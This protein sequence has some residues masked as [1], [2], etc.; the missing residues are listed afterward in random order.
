MVSDFDT[1]NILSGLV[2]PIPTLPV[3]PCIVNF[4]DQVALLFLLKILKSVRE[5]AS[6]ELIFQP[7]PAPLGDTPNSIPQPS[8]IHVRPIISC[9]LSFVGLAV[10]RGLTPLD[11]PAI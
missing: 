6:G 7:Y 4:S 3:L 10:V 5:S 2:V 9:A 8:E 11:G 1:V